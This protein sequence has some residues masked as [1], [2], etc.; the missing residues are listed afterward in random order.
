MALTD[1]DKKR[2]AREVIVNA[3]DIEYSDVY[4]H[5]ELEDEDEDTWREV[6][7]LTLTATVTVSWD[8]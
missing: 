8:D 1:E 2:I 6:H 4:E 3:T 7:D 5:Y